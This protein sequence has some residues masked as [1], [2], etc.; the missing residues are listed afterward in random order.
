MGN[1]VP[2]GGS[3]REDSQAAALLLSRIRAEIRKGVNRGLHYVDA[4]EAA[5]VSHKLA[6]G[7][8]DDC[9]ELQFL[10]EASWERDRKVSTRPSDEPESPIEI[11]HSYLRALAD[12]G[13]FS[14]SVEM[15]RRAE[16][17]DDVGARVISGHLQ[18]VA[19]ELWPKES[20]AKVEKSDGQNVAELTVEQLEKLIELRRKQRVTKQAIIIDA[21]KALE[22]RASGSPDPAS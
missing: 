17:D 8:K 1:L 13:L 15:V 2:A 19:K 11:K 7:L 18:Y 21:K 4:A 16:I 20:N 10:Y 9:P 3:R 5:G 22:E 12:A 6:M 14:K